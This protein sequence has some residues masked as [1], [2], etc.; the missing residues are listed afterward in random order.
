MSRIADLFTLLCVGAGLAFFI[1]GTAGLLRLPDTLTRIHALAKADNVGLALVVIG[2][3]PQA[4]SVLNGAKMIAVWLLAQLA[5]GAAAQLMAGVARPQDTAQGVPQD[6]G[7]EQ[8][9]R[10]DAAAG[11]GAA[12]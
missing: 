2:L 8:V 3:L 9:S 12:P 7:R 10:N 4:G 11:G 1:A 5:S 6:G